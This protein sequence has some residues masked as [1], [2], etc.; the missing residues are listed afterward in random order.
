MGVGSQMPG[1][2]INDDLSFLRLESGKVDWTKV[3]PQVPIGRVQVCHPQSPAGTCKPVDWKPE[4]APDWVARGREAAL[5]SEKI[6]KDAQSWRSNTPIAS[7]TSPNASGV[8]RTINVY[9]Y[10]KEIGYVWIAEGPSS[11]AANSQLFP[12]YVLASKFPEWVAAKAS[13]GK[14]SGG[15]SAALPLLLGAA[16]FLLA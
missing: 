13:L 12:E 6:V 14:S 10:N 3:I 11:S 7:W 8:A 2:S 9:G 16:Y 15:G 1:T 5:E 4:T